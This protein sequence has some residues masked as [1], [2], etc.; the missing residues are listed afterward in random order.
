[1]TVFYFREPSAHE[2]KWVEK[3]KEDIRILEDIF[4][5]GGVTNKF[6]AV[7]EIGFRKFDIT[8]TL[9]TAQHGE[10]KLKL[11]DREIMITA[12]K[13]GQWR[14]DPKFIE[15]ASSPELRTQYQ[16]EAQQ[17]QCYLAIQPAFLKYVKENNKNIHGFFGKL[18]QK[19]SAHEGAHAITALLHKKELTSEEVTTLQ[20]TLLLPQFKNILPKC[21]SPEKI[22]H[23]LGYVMQKEGGACYKPNAAEAQVP[24][25]T[26]TLSTH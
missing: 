21:D 10:F 15:F 1:M 20:E 9:F 19:T 3:H 24:S 11:S 14:L 26:V 7:N 16:R 12:Y 18:T 17:Q 2:H 8:N 23:A 4:N 6:T 22:L 13:D 5:L 25:I